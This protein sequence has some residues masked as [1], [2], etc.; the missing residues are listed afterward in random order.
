MD[1]EHK[2]DIS[3]AVA[4]QVASPLDFIKLEFVHISQLT[5]QKHSLSFSPPQDCTLRHKLPRNFKKG[6]QLV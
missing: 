1:L 2:T 4:K 5:F 6:V 3:D